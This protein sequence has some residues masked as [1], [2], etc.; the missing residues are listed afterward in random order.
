MYGWE[1]VK[2]AVE[3]TEDERLERRLSE[4]EVADGQLDNRLY[5]VRRTR[6][7]LEVM[8]GLI[9]GLYAALMALGFNYMLFVWILHVNFGGW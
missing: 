4:A 9:L 6:P 7:Y 8:G 2:R 5:L 1:E 3:R